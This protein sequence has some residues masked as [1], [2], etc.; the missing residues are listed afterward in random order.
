[1][2]RDLER[3]PKLKQVVAAL[4]EPRLRDLV[5]F[6][7]RFCEMPTITISSSAARSYRQIE[8]FDLIDSLREEKVRVKFRGARPEHE[9]FRA[10]QQQSECSTAPASGDEAEEGVGESEPNGD[11]SPRALLVYMLAP[12]PADAVEE[13]HSPPIAL[14]G[15]ELGA[16]GSERWRWTRLR[17]LSAGQFE[18]QLS[19]SPDEPPV[20][21]P[22]LLT[23]EPTSL[24]GFSA[25]LRCA[26]TNLLLFI[27]IISRYCNVRTINGSTCTVHYLYSPQWHWAAAVAGGGRFGHLPAAARVAGARGSRTSSGAPLHYTTR[28]MYSFTSSYYFLYFVIRSTMY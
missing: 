22:S 5:C 23:G 7:L 8:H 24:T 27:S 21:A 2:D 19:Q 14:P 16:S 17:P 28:T 13:M 11:E 25:P 3:A 1:M 26:F 20:A 12:P 18:P 6:L 4:Q 15:R 10:A 9:K